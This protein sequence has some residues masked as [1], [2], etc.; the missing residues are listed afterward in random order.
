MSDST[1]VFMPESAYGPTNNCIGIG[2]V[3]RARGHRVVRAG[4]DEQPACW[5]QLIQGTNVG[6]ELGS[7]SPELMVARHRQPCSRRSGDRFLTEFEGA[8]TFRGIGIRD[9]NGWSQERT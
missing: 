3:L 8:L 4:D 1:I 2:D 7:R 6:I 5:L 9:E